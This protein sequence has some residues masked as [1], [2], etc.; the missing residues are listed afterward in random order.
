MMLESTLLDRIKQGQKEDPGLIRYKESVE[1]ENK[2]DF[3][4]SIDVVIR[5][6]GILCYQM[7]E[8]LRKRF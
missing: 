1:V 4:A 7:I 3:S 6:Q 8:A 2:S 5:F